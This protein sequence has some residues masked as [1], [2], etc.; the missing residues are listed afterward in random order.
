MKYA[1][2]F[3]QECTCFSE[4]RQGTER[5]KGKNHV[6]TQMENLLWHPRMT[7]RLLIVQQWF[8]DS[9]QISSKSQDHFEEHE[10]EHC[11]VSVIFGLL[12]FKVSP[13]THKLMAQ[14]PDDGH[15]GK[16]LDPEVSNFIRGYNLLPLLRSNGNRKW[17]LIVGRRWWGVILGTVS[18]SDI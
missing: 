6:D 1:E 10:R 2:C 8:I 17:V 7:L 11:S 18:G 12:W 15:L 4:V 14:L 3:H 9:Y 5:A 16:L 13:K